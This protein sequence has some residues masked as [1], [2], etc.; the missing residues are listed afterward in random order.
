MEN[1][2]SKVKVSYQFAFEIRPFALRPVLR[3][4]KGIEGHFSEELASETFTGVSYLHFAPPMSAGLTWLSTNGSWL[5]IL[6]AN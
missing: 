4:S 1:T 2:S 6:N 3:G 5:F